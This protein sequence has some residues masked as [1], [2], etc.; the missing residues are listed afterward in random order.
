MGGQDK[1]DA[2][3]QAAVWFGVSFLVLLAFGMGVY[4]LRRHLLGGHN[5]PEK[6]NLLDLGT[7]TELRDKGALSEAEYKALRARALGEVL[8]RPSGDRSGR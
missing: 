1:T 8:D 2:L 4:V 3:I 5:R 7:L 6:A